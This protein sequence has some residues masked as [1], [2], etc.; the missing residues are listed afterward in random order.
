MEAGSIE[1]FRQKMFVSYCQQT[2]RGV[3][4][5]WLNSGIENVYELEG[6]GGKEEVLRFFFGYFL[7]HNAQIVR[8][9]PF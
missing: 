4:S 9:R 3:F 1:V 8:R 2:R 6:G 7:S 5:V